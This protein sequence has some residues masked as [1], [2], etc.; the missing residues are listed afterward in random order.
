MDV[1]ATIR[2]LIAALLEG[3]RDEVLNMTE[4]LNEWLARG[5]YLSTQ[6]EILEVIQV[7]VAYAGRYPLQPSV[8]HDH[9]S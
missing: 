2:Q 7:E 8:N 6:A 1:T 9:N 4:N 3:D 5:G